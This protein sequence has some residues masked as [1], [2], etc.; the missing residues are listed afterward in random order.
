MLATLSCARLTNVSLS[1][2]EQRKSVIYYKYIL[3]YNVEF[4][5]IIWKV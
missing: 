2:K 3:Y 5:S 1:K 4:K